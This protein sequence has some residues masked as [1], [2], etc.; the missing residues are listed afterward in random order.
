MKS[1]LSL[2]YLYKINSKRLASANWDMTLE[3]DEAVK[4]NELITLASST[5]LRMIDK[6]NKGKYS[7][8]RVRQIKD[9][10]GQIKRMPMSQETKSLMKKKQKELDNLLFMEDY[11]CVIMESKKDYDR[12]NKGFKVNGV[13][14]VRLLA[15][16]GGVKKSTIVFVSKRVHKTL[17][18]W[19]HNGRDTSKQFV[20]AKLEAYLSL[21]CSASIPVSNPNGVLVVHDV[22]TTF[23]DDVIVV[24]GLSGGRPKITEV[25]DYESTLNAC[26]GLGLMT[27][28]LAKRWSEEV[29]E[30]YL[31]AGVCLRN[32]FCKGMI[33]TFDFQMFSEEVAKTNQVTDV[34]G[35]VH[36]INEIELVLTTSMLKLW[37]SYTSIDHYLK[38]CEENNHTFAL[39]KITPEELDNEQTLN[40][41][42]LQSLD[43]DDEDIRELCE[44]T[45][46]E[47]D[48]ILHFDVQKT[49]LYL[50]G[51]DLKEKSVRKGKYD[52]TTGLMVDPDLLKD[53]Y[54]F[55]KIKNT[56]KNRIDRAKLGVLN[57][58]GN[59]SIASG[60]PYLLCESM[61]GLEPRGLLKSG[62]FYSKYWID[63]G[64][65]QVMGFRAPMTVHNNI[66]ICKIVN[67]EEKAKWYKYMDTVFILNGW[68]NTCAK[69]NG[70]DFDGDTMFTTDNPIIAKGVHPTKAI[71][72][73]QSSSQ[74]TIPTEKDFI[75]A[76]KQSFGSAIG[77]ITNYATSMYNVIS[78]FE[79]GTPEWEELNYR[80]MCM[81]DYQ[82][83]E[84]DKAKGCESRPVPKEWYNYKENKIFDED[85]EEVKQK[86]MFNLS[87]LAN[88][89]P[90]FF[91]YNYDKLKKEYRDYMKKSEI[92]CQKNYLMSLEEL[93]A[94][95]NPT[96]Q[97]QESLR[98][99]K[100]NNPVNMN[101]SIMNRIAWLIEDRF[102][103]FKKY[104][105]K[106]FDKEKFKTDKPYATNIYNRIKKLKK[107]YDE[108]VQQSIKS[109]VVGVK[110]NETSYE[111]QD[112]RKILKE[113]FV[114]KAYDICPNT[115]ELCN[116]MVD[117]CYSEKNSGKSK[118]FA[119]DIVG[120]QMIENLLNNNGRKAYFPMKDENGELTYK[121]LNFI[122]KEIDM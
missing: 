27:P 28:T 31:V 52:Y 106:E 54:V 53:E 115:E 1:L 30:D 93:E 13:E 108:D 59:F 103:D 99:F 89:K 107:K 9:E 118:Q 32:A 66:Q 78:N 96:L 79:E 105:L 39:A 12:A 25:N 7:E 121:G 111:M 101:P 67:D 38:C 24:D 87:I 95:E 104:D 23:K 33:F 8:E 11:L 116:I 62:E 40:Y 45:L 64:V 61:F 37:D 100:I 68:D 80:L 5:V 75:K 94:L 19:I 60:D 122:V 84:I 22:E 110:T 35:Q 26:D 43:L 56:I 65:E 69:E 98:L 92:N 86:K 20:P 88:K 102:K 16:S 3:R 10:I 49:I 63:R 2:R 47:I 71:M 50:R 97:Q 112:A 29:E 85:S 21:A 113:H 91:I 76:N 120:E 77:T 73:L 36:N 44:P 15:T 55:K 117:L 6:I 57:V 18:K 58:R 119:W 48:D 90:Y 34:W 83:A 42:F 72:C 17:T 70:M 82:Q 109:M 41:Q 46:Q 51:V 81:Q 114:K 4:H 74:K 14:Y